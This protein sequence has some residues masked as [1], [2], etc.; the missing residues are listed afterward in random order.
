MRFERAIEAQVL[1]SATSWYLHCVRG[2]PPL[3]PCVVRLVDHGTAVDQAH[4]QLRRAIEVER[5]VQ[6]EEPSHDVEC[7]LLASG[8]S[9]VVA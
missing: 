8:S 1:I 6:H 9:L 7:P 3:I 4:E 5:L 2:R